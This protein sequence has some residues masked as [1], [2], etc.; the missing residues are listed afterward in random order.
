MPSL[1]RAEIGAAGRGRILLAEDDAE[2]R[3][4]LGATLRGAGYEV[5]EA[6]D[7]DGLIEK[8][9]EALRPD[10]SGAAFDLILSDIRMPHFSA[11][12]VLVGARRFIA[13]I[14]VVLITAFGD[15]STHERARRRGATVVL[16]K[17]V[18]LSELCATVE[19]V[20]ARKAGPPWPPS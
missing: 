3:A 2:L 4:L 19:R 1:E 16:N 18:R 15:A 20:I 13:D 8:L 12:D 7:G 10:H 17:P 14:P 5:V 9:A 11:L 6:S